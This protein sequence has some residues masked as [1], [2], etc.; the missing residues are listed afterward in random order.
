M[1]QTS[2][3]NPYHRVYVGGFSQGGVM[4]LTYSMQSKV[5][6][7]GA[8]CFSGYMLRS[9]SYTNFMKFPVLIAHGTRDPIIR[10]VMAQQSYKKLLTD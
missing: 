10:E 3:I 1:E 9:V 2:L 4:A 5:P 8:I 7:A 6:P